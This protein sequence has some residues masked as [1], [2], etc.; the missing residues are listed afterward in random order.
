MCIRVSGSGNLHRELDGQLVDITDLACTELRNG[1]IL[2]AVSCSDRSIS[3]WDAETW[4][5]LCRLEGH[6]LAVNAV[7]FVEVAVSFF[8]SYLFQTAL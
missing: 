5:S 1:I 3:L 7:V 2:L 6:L 8:F 4:T